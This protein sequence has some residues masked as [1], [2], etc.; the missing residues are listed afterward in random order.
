VDLLY[1]WGNVDVS[2]SAEWLSTQSLRNM[3]IMWRS[4]TGIRQKSDPAV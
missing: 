2:P 4:Q 3:F 1:L